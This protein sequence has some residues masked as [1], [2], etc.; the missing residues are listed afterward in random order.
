M[1][2]LSGARFASG[3]GNTAFS[4]GGEEHGRCDSAPASTSVPRLP[5]GE[6]N[7]DD[8]T[9]RHAARISQFPGRVQMT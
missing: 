4:V 1:T 6:K 3:P 8:A 2:D 5:S 9:P 7:T